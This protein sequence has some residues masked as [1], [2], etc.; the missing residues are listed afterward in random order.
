MKNFIPSL[1]AMV[2][3]NLKISTISKEKDK[4]R[5]VL[6]ELLKVQIKNKQRAS[7]TIQAD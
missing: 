4:D 7:T 6:K 5:E 2:R 3:K 1:I